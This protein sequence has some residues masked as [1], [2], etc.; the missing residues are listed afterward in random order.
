MIDEPL[1]LSAMLLL[2]FTIAISKYLDKWTQN[3]HAL[4]AVE[5]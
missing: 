3:D 5:R 2:C 4:Y 1:Y